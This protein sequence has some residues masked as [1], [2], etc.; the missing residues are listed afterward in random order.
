[1]DQ[2]IQKQ[3]HYSSNAGI[4]SKNPNDQEKANTTQTDNID[5]IYDV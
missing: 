5:P 2:I 3:K 4:S 1:M